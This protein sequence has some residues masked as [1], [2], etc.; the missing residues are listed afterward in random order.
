MFTPMALA[1]HPSAQYRLHPD[2]EIDPTDTFDET[3][4]RQVCNFRSLLSVMERRALIDFPVAASAGK[5]PGFSD[6]ICVSAD[7]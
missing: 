5:H 6:A 4:I 3:F 7:S 1:W 2:T